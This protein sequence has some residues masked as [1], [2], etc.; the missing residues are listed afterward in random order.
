MSIGRGIA[1]NDAGGGG[2]VENAVDCQRICQTRDGCGAWIWNTEN[3]ARR[4]KLC[5][6]KKAAIG[7]RKTENDI[8]RVSGPRNCP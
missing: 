8:N 5:F 1:N 3:H 2:S 6:L 4:P 7:Y